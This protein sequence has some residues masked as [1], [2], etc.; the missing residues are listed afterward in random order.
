MEKPVKIL[1]LYFVFGTI[2][3]QLYAQTKFGIKG[4][5]NAS[6]IAVSLSEYSPEYYV[7]NET[8]YKYNTGFNGGVFVEF[9]L[10]K[11]FSFQPE[12]ALSVKGMRSETSIL[13]NR[14]AESGFS[15]QELRAKSKISL[16]YIEL[17]LY[18]KYSLEL[19]KS[20]K[21][22]AGT[23]LHLAYGIS[24]DMNSE[25][26]LLESSKHWTGKK[27]IF[28]EDD[29]NFNESTWVNVGGLMSNVASW[30]REPYWHK[31]I[32]RFDCGIFIFA[33]YEL[34]MNWF[35]TVSYN[36]GLLNLLNSAEV[37][38][39]MVEGKLYNRTVSVSFGYK[40]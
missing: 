20:R 10:T 5:V 12:L 40:F 34:N 11:M 2:C 26:V 16:Y 4:G 19:N 9:P 23:G 32:K 21:F 14:P 31:S 6:T 3:T 25:F 8:K 29:I 30:V 24:G 33:G 1:V 13:Q 7:Q 15:T 38:D 18:I 35:I 28:K 39:G 17:P 37:W 36:M 22:I 27:D